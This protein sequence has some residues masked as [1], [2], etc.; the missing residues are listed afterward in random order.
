VSIER[1]SFRGFQ[2]NLPRSRIKQRNQQT[3]DLSGPDGLLLLSSRLSESPVL[4]SELKIFQPEEIF[5]FG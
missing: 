2:P 5:L 1:N 4:L 3:A